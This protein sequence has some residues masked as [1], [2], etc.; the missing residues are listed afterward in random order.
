[1]PDSTTLRDGSDGL[2]QNRLSLLVRFARRRDPLIKV[3]QDTACLPAET[4]RAG[5]LPGR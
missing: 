1:V 5:L 2:N 4:A 3:L